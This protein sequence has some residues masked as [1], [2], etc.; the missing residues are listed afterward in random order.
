MKIKHIYSL[1]ILVFSASSIFAQ[2]VV[3]QHTIDGYALEYLQVSGEQSA[4]YYGKQQDRVPF[5]VNHPY[6]QNSQ[7]TKARL[8]YNN[9]IYPEVMLRLDL[10]KDELIIFSPGNRNI[11]LFPE[12]VDVAE[13]HGYKLIYFRG[14]SLSGSPSAGYYM[15][16]HSGTCKILKRQTA[17]LMIDV[18][19]TNYRYN[20][21]TNFYLFKDDVYQTIRTKRVLLKNLEPYRKELK[22]FISKNHLQFRKNSDEFFIQTLD[23]YEKLANS[24]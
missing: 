17:T 22:R 12:N 19:T 11:V 8:S 16:L 15:L 14:D 2:N 1:I 5:A 20:T 24:Q 23:E 18:G 13:L 4:L 6:L 7:Y 10:S 3:Q 9:V 21:T